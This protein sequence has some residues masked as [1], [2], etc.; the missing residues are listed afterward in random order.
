MSVLGKNAKLGLGATPNYV[1]GVRKIDWDEGA[2]SM[3]ASDLID[4]DPPTLYPTDKA[5]AVINLTVEKKSGDTNGQAAIA[6]AHA[7]KTSLQVTLAPE[8]T[9]AGSPKITGTAYVENAGKES[10]DKK[11]LV[12]KDIVLKFS[13]A[14]TMGVFP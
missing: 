1:Q 12:V 8:G 4:E 11:T 7:A 6:T 2:V 14:F 5:N 3:V 10:Y 13:G 9:T